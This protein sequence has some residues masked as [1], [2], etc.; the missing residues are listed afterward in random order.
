MP[1]RSRTG[2]ARVHSVHT[3]QPLTRNH[4]G[5]AHAQLKA[6]GR[7][8]GTGAVRF[9]FAERFHNVSLHILVIVLLTFH[10]LR[11]LW[12]LFPRVA[13]NQLVT[14]LHSTSVSLR[15]NELEHSQSSFAGAKNVSIGTIISHDQ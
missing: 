10:A 5:A 14:D 9:C 3:D 2:W 4:E 15:T 7:G 1:A 12:G 11:F 6:S 8:R 13:I